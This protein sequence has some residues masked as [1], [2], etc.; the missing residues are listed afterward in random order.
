MVRLADV[1]REEVEWLSEGR[2]P[3]GKLTLVA[4]DP[5]LGK[6]TLMIELGACV[7]RGRPFIAGGP[8]CPLGSVILLS[9]EDDAADTIRPRLEAAGGDPSRVHVVKAVKGKEGKPFSL[10]SDILALDRTLAA[11]FD[12]RL[13]IIDPVSAYLG[14]V[15]SHRDKEVRG[16]LV[17]LAELA[18]RHKVAIILVTHLNKGQGPALYRSMGS[19]GFVAAV[20]MAWLVAIDPHNSERRLLLQLKNN[21]SCDPGGLAFNL[22]GAENGPAR[23]EWEPDIVRM[24]ADDVL[25]TGAARGRPSV[26]SEQAME[27]LR[28]KLKEGP[29]DAAQISE[30]S[31]ADELAWRTVERAKKNLGIISRKSGDMGGWQWSMPE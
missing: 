22:V 11:K 15:D 29:L 14:I 25:S 10:E 6:S 7:S 30:M 5:G 20:R 19:I 9:A 8:P 23:I 28:D 12:C 1:K 24:S 13:V 17:P 31:M 2:F 4:G 21:L 18:A 3:L 26:Q 27:W 16:V